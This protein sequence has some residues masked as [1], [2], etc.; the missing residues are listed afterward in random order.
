MI[1]FVT[2]FIKI[3]DGPVIGRSLQWR[4]NHFRDLLSTG[5]QICIY[6]SSEYEIL[7]K[8]LI[9]EYKNLKINKILDIKD[10]WC[11]KLYE[12]IENIELPNIRHNDKDILEYNLLMNAKEEFVYDTIIKNPFNTTHF[13]WID[14]N[15]CHIFKNKIHTLNYLHI[16]S[17]RTLCD[18]FLTIPGCWSKTNEFSLD[19][20]SWRFC[21]GFFLGDKQSII[22]FHNLYQKYFPIFLKE[23]KKIVWE[24]NFWAYLETNH[25]WIPIW[26]KADHNDTIIQIPTELFSIKPKSISTLLNLLQFD[27][28]YPTS[29]SYIWYENKHILNTR[30]V[31]YWLYP[32]GCYLLQ[33]NTINNKNICSILDDDLNLIKSNIIDENIDLS[34]NIDSFSQGLED[35]RLYEFNGQLKFIATTVNYYDIH[36]DNKCRMII[37]NYNPISDVKIINSPY[38]QYMEKNWSPISGSNEELFIYKWWPF[39]IGEIKNN[40][41]FIKYKYEIL[42]PLFKNVKGSTTFTSIDENFIGLVH[43]SEE[44][45]PRNYFH[46]LILLD[47]N[48]KPLKY[49]ETFYFKNIGIEFCIG[50]TILNNYYHFWV[51]LHDRDTTLISISIDSLPFLFDFYSHL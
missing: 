23:Y 34:F 31:D 7:I 6:I 39:E 33:N 2:S 27:N 41:L 16:L 21:G 8:D 51:S 20:I 38:N 32:D 48:Y 45:T 15:I 28:Y 14:F 11:Y 30:L 42:N 12:T 19:T 22:H 3:Y 50:M 5:I 47:N 37:G 24:V 36:Q 44:N 13:A 49:T 17:L 40:N 35:M 1:T 26:Y 9:E 43:L 46:M 29:S 25:K 10:T 18:S 4:I